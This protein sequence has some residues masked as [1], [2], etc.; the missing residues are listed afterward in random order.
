MKI[1]I[2]LA[3]AAAAPVSDTMQLGVTTHFSQGWPI[4]LLSK[5]ETVGATTIRD[6]LHW[7]RVELQPGRYEFRDSNSRH[8]ARA[9]AAGHKVLLGIEPRNPLYDNGQTVFSPAARAAFARYILAIADRYPDCVIAIEIGNEINGRNGMTGPAA[10]NR[11]LSHTAILRD[12]YT[13][14]KPKHPGL[15]LLGGSTNTIAT[16][17]LA[18]LFEAGALDVMDGVVVHPYR[19][20]PEGVSWELARLNAAMQR[21]GKVK[22]IWATEFSKD[23][24]RP[25]AAPDFVL[26]ML[27]MMS[28]A[29]VAG[30][31]W[32]ALLD[33]KFFPTM[34]LLTIGGG[35]KP[36]AQAFGHAARDLVRRGRAVR[37]GTD[38]TA[39][40]HYR[41]G[42][43]RQVI[44]GTRRSLEVVGDATFT[45][46]DGTAIARPA[47][48]SETPIIVKGTVTVRTGPAEVLADSTYGF[49]QAPW[50]YYARRKQAAPRPLGPID[51]LW[52]TYIGTP[53]IRPMAITPV[54][55][56]L[57]GNVVAP[58]EA[59][60]RFTSTVAM[61]A[62]VSACLSPRSLK[63]DGVV[64]E[65]KHNGT[66]IWRGTLAPTQ[67]QLTAAVPVVLASSDTIDFVVGPNRTSLGDQVK[68]RFRVSRTG[69]DAA[70]CPT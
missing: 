58:I 38:D 46:A 8:V 13:L 10:I 39:L 5:V 27:T 53:A 68:Y 14:V 25:A 40:F 63:G 47:A 34:G 6:S 43:D 3:L 57:A 23:F 59:I 12:V 1:S 11:P 22:P 64:V 48:V 29:G 65:L 42:S 26:K 70:V 44:W 32:Y 24:E 30:A 4:T 33:Q 19:P 49:G 31:Y 15:A 56:T 61:P 9:C 67:P 21:A 17:F 54:G 20:E 36:A 37:I 69:R 55:M 62:F 28:G 7:P 18:R 50:N 52:T 35:D 60:V 41:F 16:G 66:S 51:W 2:A 45:A